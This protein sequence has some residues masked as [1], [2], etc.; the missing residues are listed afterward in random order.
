VD[1]RVT[2]PLSLTETRDSYSSRRPRNPLRAILDSR[3]PVVATSLDGVADEDALVTH[4][5]CGNAGVQ[6]AL[7]DSPLLDRVVDCIR[8]S[9]GTGNQRHALAPRVPLEV[10]VDHP[11]ARRVVMF[12]PV[13]VTAFGKLARNHQRP[14]AITR[15]PEPQRE[16]RVAGIAEPVHRVE[17][18]RSVR[19]PDRRIHAP[20]MSDRQRLMRVTH[21]GQPDTLLDR[22]LDEDVRRLQVNHPGLVDD[23]SVARTQ[24]VLR[25]PAVHGARA[26]IDLSHSQP[27]P[28]LRAGLVVA[29]SA[30]R[31]WLRA[32]LS[33]SPACTAR[34]GALV[35][36]RRQPARQTQ[37]GGE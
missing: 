22:E 18:N 13:D 11:L 32:R 12:D 14:L 3:E 29:P 33:S 37:A 2:T 21:E 24:H 7:I 19:V 15:I 17:L 31:V 23:D 9:V 20:R 35:I 27:G 5:P 10:R 4:P 26:G 8:L 30:R 34:G 25:R 16:R 28:H 6:L 36:E 1:T